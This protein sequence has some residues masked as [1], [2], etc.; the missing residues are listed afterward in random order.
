MENIKNF[1]TTFINGIV[2]FIC[3]AVITIIAIVIC[4]PILIIRE[5]LMAMHIIDALPESVLKVF[6]WIMVLAIADFVRI[7][8][9]RQ[10]VKGFELFY[11]AVAEAGVTAVPYY[12]D[13]DIA[14]G[15]EEIKQIVANLGGDQYYSI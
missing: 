1:A 7:E 13:G 4:V 12:V 10:G 9:R 8:M 5:V 3:A 11:A 2:D 14:G 6:A 15:R